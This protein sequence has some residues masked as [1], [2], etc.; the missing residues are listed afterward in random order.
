[1]TNVIDGLRA[2]ARKALMQERSYRFTLLALA[3][4]E[5]RKRELN[6]EIEI[7]DSALKVVDAALASHGGQHDR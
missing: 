2:A 3:K 7:W 1:M 4:S 6:R 5:R